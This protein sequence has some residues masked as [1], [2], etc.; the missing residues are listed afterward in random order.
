MDYRRHLGASAELV[1]LYLG[2]A[3]VDAADRTL[4]VE[5]D[6]QVGWWRFRAAGRRATPIGPAEV[7]DLSGLPA[8]R[9]HLMGEWLVGEAGRT[10]RV[11]LL[12][13]D[14]PPLF[15]PLRAR[16][17]HGGALVFEELEYESGIE[18]E[19]RRALEDGRSLAD[20]KGVPAPLRAAFA[21]ALADREARTLGIPV[22][23]LEI[24][25]H[26]AAIASEGRERVAI[27]LR[28]LEARR[29]AEEA[30]TREA[31]F[32]AR[33]REAALQPARETSLEERVQT[34]LEAA[35]ARL[36]RLRRM[37]RGL[38]EV[39]WDFEGETFLTLVDERG[40]RVL[41]AGICLA[42]HDAEVTLESLPAVV[43]EAIEVGEIVVTSHEPMRT[44]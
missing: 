6:A 23:P 34:A 12:P 15:S 44:R 4:R 19:V 20:V 29:N 14:E 9:G 24:R 10:E 40:L 17:W 11:Y 39:T 32:L 26:V 8:V 21:Y 36:R 7:P 35:G 38:A 22:G 27:L 2:G 28:D 37:A 25:K 31:R 3:T 18:E 5:G 42:G 16:R 13:D 30:A 43:R 33:A 41:D 1:L